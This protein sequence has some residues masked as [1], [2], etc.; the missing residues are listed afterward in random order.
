M[1]FMQNLW[2]DPNVKI[3]QP[4]KQIVNIVVNTK[5]L[6][7]NVSQILQEEDYNHLFND[8]YQIVNVQ[9][10]LNLQKMIIQN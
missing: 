6:F 4:T 9:F 3:L 7:S 5:N 2:E 8:I 10:A 1:Q